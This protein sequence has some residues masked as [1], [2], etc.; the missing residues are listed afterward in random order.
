MACSKPVS[1]YSARPVNVHHIP[2]VVERA[3][4]MSMFGTPGPVYIEMTSD[5]IHGK[6]EE[7]SVNYFPTVEL[8]VPLML[9]DS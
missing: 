1:K 8:P 3:V 9:Q 2:L 6:V 5:V 7:S 4:R